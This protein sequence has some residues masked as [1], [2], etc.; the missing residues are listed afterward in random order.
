MRAG[1]FGYKSAIQK[2]SGC[3]NVFL[4]LLILLRTR[5]TFVILWVRLSLKWRNC[6]WI[7]IYAHIR[8]STVPQPVRS[9]IRIAFPVITR[10][11]DESTDLIMQD[12]WRSW[13]GWA[14]DPGAAAA[15]GRRS[16]S[17]WL[18]DVSGA[19]GVWCRLL[20]CTSMRCVSGSMQMH[21]K[22]A[23]HSGTC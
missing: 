1:T 9:G 18:S 23:F 12:W 20:S 15:D 19:E 3:G 13:C 21:E 17:V 5:T 22:V 7:S 6:Q 2:H 10:Y 11:Q 16:I 14:C 4:V 8:L